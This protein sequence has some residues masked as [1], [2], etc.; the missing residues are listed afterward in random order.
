MRTLT[1][2]FGGFIILLAGCATTASIP[3]EDRTFYYDAPYESVMDAI[4][5]T[6]IEN[7]ETIESVDR[8]NGLIRT[9]PRGS[10][11]VGRALFGN[12]ERSFS[13]YVRPDGDRTRVVM[14]F[15]LQDVNAFGGRTET[16]VTGG[17]ARQMYQQTYEAIGK[18]L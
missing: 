11:A 8:E 13:A 2:I 9:A 17:H 6:V 14:T 15:S 4:I 16:P 5:Q 7:G 1:Y 3:A 18:R 10:G 12:M